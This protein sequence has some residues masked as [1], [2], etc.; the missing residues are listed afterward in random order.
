MK[1][2]EM[3]ILATSD[4]HS[5]IFPVN[6]GK[7]EQDQQ[8][9]VKAATIIKEHRE[10]NKH[11]LLIDNGDLIQGTP[12][13]DYALTQDKDR[14][15]PAIIVHN[16]LQYD[17]V[18]IGN[19]EFN[20]GKETLQ[21][22]MEQSNFP[23][24]SA[25]VVKKG[26]ETPLFGKPYLIRELEGFRIAVL[27]LTTKYIPHWES[28]KHIVDMDFLDPIDTANKWI[29]YLKKVENIDFIIVSYHGGLEKN[30]ETLEGNGQNNGENQGY[31]LA[32][33]VEGIDCLITGHQHLLYAA[34]LAN[35]VSVIQPG[36]GASH[37]GKISITV[38]KTNNKWE[39]K[40]KHASLIPTKKAEMDET[41]LAAVQ[42]I[43][44]QADNWLN[45]SIGR[46]E[47]DMTIQQPMQQVWVQEHPLIEWINKVQM[48]EAK[49]DISCTAL[50]NPT[51]KG[52]S[53]N[54]SRNDIM[55]AYPFPNTLVV[56]ELTGEEIIQAIEVS[57][58]FL[59]LEED[60]EIT[61]H[62]DWTKPRLL[63]Y[64]YDMWE[65]INYQIDISKP[66]GH[67]VINTMYHG[68]PLHNHTYQVVMNNY[69]ASGSGGYDMFNQS[70]VVKEI[71]KEIAN[72]LIEDAIINKNIPATVN[73]NWKV[74]HK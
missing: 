74:I 17:A 28:P 65:G 19:H 47:G 41:V 4:V 53:G 43:A 61:V 24:L 58:S 60:G 11:V 66:I 1:S 18:V 30:P 15:H 70:K 40:K 25:N 57:A 5:H 32:T 8:G 73:H 29:S 37:I 45:Q 69:R 14:N 10:K 55:N 9:M 64:N 46:V 50:L 6:E 27:G 71:Q 35:G 7:S 44:S 16:L 62:P 20:Y 42:S 13:A 63:S 33:E 12:L 3:I 49:V 31:R 54:I 59:Q 23:W 38:S 34:D 39:I 36:T 21:K 72:L 68:E 48:K 2:F 67:R 26:T 51:I 52:I 56:M 22:I